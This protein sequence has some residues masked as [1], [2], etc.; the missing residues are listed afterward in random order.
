MRKLT[1]STL[2]KLV[3]INELP[4]VTV[5]SKPM[6]QWKSHVG[7]RKRLI[8]ERIRGH[9]LIHGLLVS[10]GWLPGIG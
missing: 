2:A 3:A 7:L 9:N 10:Q 6:L 1:D 5:S 4:T 8:S